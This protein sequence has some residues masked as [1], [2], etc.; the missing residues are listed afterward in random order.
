[1]LA[2]WGL[3]RELDCEG[4]AELMGGVEAEGDLGGG[5]EFWWTHILGI[6][7]WGVVAGFVPASEQSRASHDWLQWWELRRCSVQ[8]R[9]EGKCGLVWIWDYGWEWNAPIINPLCQP[10]RDGNVVLEVVCPLLGGPL[11]H[12]GWKNRICKLEIIKAVS[13]CYAL[14]RLLKRCRMTSIKTKVKK[15]AGWEQPRETQSKGC[16]RS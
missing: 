9:L 11:L 5:A 3:G 14:L 2:I 6:E 13:F 12:M 4:R 15:F 1:M 7:V 16:L 8:V 10:A